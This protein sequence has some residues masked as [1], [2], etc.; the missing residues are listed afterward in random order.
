MRKDFYV[1]RHGETD[2]NK[3]RKLQG[4]GR[5]IALN[6]I[7]IKQG[8]QLAEKLKNIRLE[9][10]YSSPLKRAL[11]TAAFVA[12]SQDIPV[13]VKDDLRECCY[14]DAEGMDLDEVE[15]L[16]PEIKKNWTNPKVWDIRY[17]YGESKRE[18]LERV[19]SRIQEL[20]EAP[21]KSIG[22]AVHAGTM[23]SLLNFMHFDF[24]NIPN[25]AVFHLVYVDNTWYVEGE[26]F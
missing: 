7:G 15:R 4:S 18:A 24:K 21:E 9:A 17:P 20:K 12:E 5:D 8:R 2:Y 13:I 1:F 22:V 10:I 25:C 11:Q 26:L 14:G 3:E 6:E 19:W 16:Y 23:G